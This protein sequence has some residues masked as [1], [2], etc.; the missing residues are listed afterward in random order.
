MDRQ[1]HERFLAAN[2]ELREFLGRADGLTSGACS[3]TECE[4]KGLSRRLSTLAPE[5]GDVSRSE[6]L[7]ADWPEE[8]AQY[9]NNLR[10]LRIALEKVRSVML[11]R[12][13]QIEAQRRHFAG[14]QSWVKAYQQTT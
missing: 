14:L 12:K 11:A 1:K 5:V 2:Q 7:S 3:I 8:V 9:V 6:T 10:A 4:L 13:T